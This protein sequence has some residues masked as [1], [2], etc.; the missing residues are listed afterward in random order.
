MSWRSLRKDRG[1]AAA[2]LVTLAIGLSGHA[3]MV[4][5][6]NTT[7]LHPLNVPEPDRI[8]LMANQ[9]PLMASARFGAVS[10]PPDYEDRRASITA[11]EDQAMYNF[12]DVTIDSGGVPTRLRGIAGTPSLLRLLRAKISGRADVSGDRC[13]ASATTPTICIPFIDSGVIPVRMIRPSG[14]SEPKASRAS[15]SFTIATCGRPSRSPSPKSRPRRIGMFTV[16]KYPGVT[17]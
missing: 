2:A 14:S 3:A 15:R 1:F 6:V 7:L 9:Y 10:A 11:L 5:A 12:A 17:I 13:R 8:Y 4:A 16:S